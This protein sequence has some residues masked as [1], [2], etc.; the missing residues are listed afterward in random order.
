M[1]RVAVNIYSNISEGCSRK[2]GKDFEIFPRM[3][4]GSLSELECQ[5]FLIRDI[6]NIDI[7]KMIVSLIRKV[8]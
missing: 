1:E 3:S 7:S 4:F 2:T 5:F 6:Y 8:E